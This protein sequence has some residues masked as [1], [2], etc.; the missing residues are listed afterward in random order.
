MPPKLCPYTSITNTARHTI[1]S[2]RRK[3]VSGKRLENG[4][5]RTGATSVASEGRDAMGP[6]SAI[7]R[8]EAA[9]HVAIARSR[10]APRHALG[11]VLA[12]CIQERRPLVAFGEQS[13]RHAHEVLNVARRKDILA[14]MLRNQLTMTADARAHE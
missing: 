4:S 12:S 8:H 9:V 10:I 11:D 5:T 2:Q 1:V 14:Q 6:P 7:G 13:Q 3:R